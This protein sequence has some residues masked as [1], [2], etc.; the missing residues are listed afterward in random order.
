MSWFEVFKEFAIYAGGAAIVW[1]TLIDTA[2]RGTNDSEAVRR[3][4]DKLDM[5]LKKEGLQ[6][7]PER[8]PPE[9]DGDKPEK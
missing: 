9:K 2:R 8:K 7:G 5:L 3:I 6:Y 1:G 4:E